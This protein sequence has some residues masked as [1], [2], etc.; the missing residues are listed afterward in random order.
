MCV[1]VSVLQ[2]YRTKRRY[3]YIYIERE[4]ERDYDKLVKK[5]PDLPSAS[6]RPRKAMCNSVLS[7]RA[8]EAE[9]M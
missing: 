3:I 5:S 4:R 1:L 6:W 7:L 9:K 2:R 8:C